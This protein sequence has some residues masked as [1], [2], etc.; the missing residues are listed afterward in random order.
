MA[1]RYPLIILV[2]LLAQLSAGSDAS[3]AQGSASVPDNIAALVHTHEGESALPE[4]MCLSSAHNSIFS[5]GSRVQ[6]ASVRSLSS[7]RRAQ[8]QLRGSSRV[9]RCGKIIDMRNFCPILTT[10]IVR[11]NG[12]T[13]FA[14]YIFSICC[15][16]I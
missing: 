1:M 13:S 10:V 16:R 2:W 14:R 12:A 7:A 3:L 9:V 8:S 4:Q 5:G 15:L 6:E 11:E